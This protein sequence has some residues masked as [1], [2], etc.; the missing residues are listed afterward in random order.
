MTGSR[1]AD[2]R[3]LVCLIRASRAKLAGGPK[4]DIYKGLQ[5]AGHEPPRRDHRASR[6]PVKPMRGFV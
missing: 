3:L 1:S 2:L 4:G 5:V 6:S